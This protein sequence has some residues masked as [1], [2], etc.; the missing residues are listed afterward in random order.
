MIEFPIN[1]DNIYLEYNYST[2]N[3]RLLS[4]TKYIL[5]IQNFYAEILFKYMI[6]RYGYEE[7][8]LR[9]AGLIKSSLDRSM[10]ALNAGEVEKHEQLIQIVVKQTEKSL[11]L[12]NDTII[13]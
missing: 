10:C 13:N 3:Y 1:F 6:F 12:Q 8:A 4:N 9:F 2:N 11:I 7:A 5:D